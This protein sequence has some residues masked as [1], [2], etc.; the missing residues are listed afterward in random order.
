MAKDPESSSSK[1][2]PTPIQRKRRLPTWQSKTGNAQS[3]IQ[4]YFVILE[5][6]YVD[7]GIVYSFQLAIESV[8][9]IDIT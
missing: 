9:E 7:F 3:S 5:D 1:D 2:S 6:A 8:F 4:C